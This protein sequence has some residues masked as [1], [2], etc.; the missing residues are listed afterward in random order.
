MLLQETGWSRWLPEGRGLVSFR[1][2]AEAE[3]KAR[4]IEMD[5]AR[6]AKAA[7]EIAKEHLAAERA[8]G[9]SLRHL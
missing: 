5:H 2:P 6:H 4:K 3:E 8:I 1:T 7:E 9:Q